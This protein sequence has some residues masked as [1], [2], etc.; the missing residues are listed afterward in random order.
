MTTPAPRP[1]LERIEAD[2]SENPHLHEFFPEVPALLAYVRR[3]EGELHTL[4]RDHCIERHGW[5]TI[6]N[7]TQLEAIDAMHR[8]AEVP[9]IVN[10]MHREPSAALNEEEK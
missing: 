2:W 7:G 1:D 5:G 6:P 4:R 10:E 3:L 8:L 9:D